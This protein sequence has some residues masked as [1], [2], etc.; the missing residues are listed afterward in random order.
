[1]IEE[2]RKE[3]ESRR[4]QKTRENKISNAVSAMI[5]SVEAEAELRVAN[6][7]PE[8][9]ERLLKQYGFA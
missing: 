9:K 3:K 7:T 6:M 8:E 5:E 1:M 4:Q 2:K